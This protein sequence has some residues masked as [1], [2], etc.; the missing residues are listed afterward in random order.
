MNDFVTVNQ[1]GRA[2]EIRID[3]PPANAINRQVSDE[4]HNA[5]KT[6]QESD[7]LRVG[8]ITGS[9]DKIFC[10]GWDL[11]EVAQT[12]DTV[13]VPDEAI[14]APGGFGGICEYWD[15]KK[16]VIAAVNGHAVGGGLEIAIACDIILAVDNADFFLPEMQR[17]FLPDAGA[18]QHLGRLVKVV[19]EMILTGRRM[20][21]AEAKSWGLVHQVYSAG[22]L[23]PAAR[24]MAD[25]IAE[26]APLTLQALKEVLY[27]MLSVSLPE[28]FEITRQ[29]VRTKQPGKGRFPV[30]ETMLASEDFLEGAVA[31]AEKRDPKFKGG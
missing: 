1:R 12:T 16:P 3:R 27:P 19:T 7:E 28:A 30:Y 13:A 9:G 17:G 26:G 25:Q 23:M 11:K 15:L 24:A 6:L 22:E 18:V 8:I 14:G 31:F 5:L 10:A 2:L 4:I 21:A 29:A 20:P